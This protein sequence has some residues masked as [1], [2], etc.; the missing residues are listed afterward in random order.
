MI[1][2]REKL[3]EVLAELTA[4]TAKMR[5]VFQVNPSNGSLRTILRGMESV[6]GILRNYLAITN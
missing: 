1:R 4:T 5:E 3:E 6:L 2:D